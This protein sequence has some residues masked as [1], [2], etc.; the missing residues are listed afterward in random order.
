MSTYFKVAEIFQTLFI[1]LL[2]LKNWCSF[3]LEFYLETI[4][5]PDQFFKQFFRYCCAKICEKCQVMGLRVKDKSAFLICIT[6]Q[7]PF[8]LCDKTDQNMP[9]VCCFFL[10]LHSNSALLTPVS[11]SYLV[12]DQQCTWQGPS[13][14]CFPVRLTCLSVSVSLL[15]Q[16][17]DTFFKFNLTKCKYKT[18]S[19]M[20]SNPLCKIT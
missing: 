6:V 11:L 10:V 19:W 14:E 5:K 3:C 1:Q 4:E 20:A 7:R 16:T 2:V 13:T 18:I 9:C 8:R 17:C 15:I 12:C